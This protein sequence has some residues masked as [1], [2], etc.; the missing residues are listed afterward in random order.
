M[1]SPALNNLSA[2]I[3][4]PV[5]FWFLNGHIEEWHIVRELEMMREK[6][7]SEFVV[8]PRYGLDVE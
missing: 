7:I 8:H 2:Q 6:G 4:S 3:H 1:N 5:P